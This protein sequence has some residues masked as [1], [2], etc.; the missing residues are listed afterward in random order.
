MSAMPWKEAV[1]SVTKVRT[2]SCRIARYTAKFRQV[3]STYI[4]KLAF[5][6]RLP[7]STKKGLPMM[8]MI[9]P[10]KAVIRMAVQTM[11]SLKME[12]KPGISSS[13]TFLISFLRLPPL[14]PKILSAR[15]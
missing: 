11:F 5:S 4:T 3:V 15:M 9:T 2:P 6:A 8:A 7:C 1:S 10:K 13:P 14:V 12:K